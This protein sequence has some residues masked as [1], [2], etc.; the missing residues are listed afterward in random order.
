M[1]NFSYLFLYTTLGSGKKTFK[2][3]IRRLVMFPYF[4]SNGFVIR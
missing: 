1:L 3:K 4:S 2:P